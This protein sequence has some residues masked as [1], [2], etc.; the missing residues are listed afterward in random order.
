ME[1]EDGDLRH[2]TSLE[3]LV[4]L[5]GISQG[6]GAAGEV[7][8]V[9]IIIFVV[10]VCYVFER[11]VLLINALAGGVLVLRRSGCGSG[12][13]CWVAEDI[14]RVLTGSCFGNFFC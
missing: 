2:V 11:E 7:D 1:G 6:N 9:I 8:S 14:A 10:L 3:K 12:C 5:D 4:I 13:G